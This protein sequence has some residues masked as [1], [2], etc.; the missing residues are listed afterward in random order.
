[1]VFYSGAWCVALKNLLSGR[2]GWALQ[3]YISLFVAA[4]RGKIND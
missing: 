4:P 1:M 2:V 3:N